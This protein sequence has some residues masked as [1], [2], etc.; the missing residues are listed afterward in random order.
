MNELLHTTLKN[1]KTGRVPFW[2]MRQ[3]G[4]YLPEYRELRQKAGGF[5]ELCFNPEWAAEVTIQPIRR[6]HMDAAIVFSDILVVPKAM[7]QKVWFEKGE[8]PRLEVLQDRKAIERLTTQVEQELSPIAETLKR[9]REELPKGI[10][11]IGFC[12]APW[13]VACY[14][15]EGKTKREY[16]TARQFA[17]MQEKDFSLLID[18]LVDASYRY[19]CLQVEAG[20][21]VLQI[22]DSW[23]GVLSEAE[24]WQWVIK[25]TQKLVGKVKSRYPHIPIIG[26]PR[27]SG[28]KYMDYDKQIGV[29]AIGID[30]Q[31]PFSWAAKNL[32]KPIQGNLDPL[33]LAGDQKLLLQQAK[34]ILEWGKNKAFIFN[35]GHGIV[36]HTPVE[37][38][39]ALSDFLLNA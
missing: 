31:T 26:F 36:Q 29:D 8:G 37:N 12:G 27:G 17:A 30:T 22:F 11:L 2:F 7:G 19:L 21:D 18:K 13:T 20:A 24:Y 3:A 38:V 23:A 1:K 25:P 10:S 9:V 14:M 5:L 16:E 33:L 28:A 34:K 32:S 6:F 15:V 39:Q 35:L 4:R